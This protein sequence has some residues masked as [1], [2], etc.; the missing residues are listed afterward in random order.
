MAE[1]RDCIPCNLDQKACRRHC[2]FF[3]TGMASTQD[4]MIT[5]SQKDTRLSATASH[6]PSDFRH[7]YYDHSDEYQMPYYKRRRPLCSQT[8]LAHPAVFERL[9]KAGIAVHSYDCHGHGRSEP[10]EERSRALIWRFHHVVRLQLHFIAH[11]PRLVN[12]ML[13][14]PGI[15]VLQPVC[16]WG[17][18]KVPS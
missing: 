3:I 5:V 6:I 13:C 2:L 16:T 4:A 8:L 10:Q 11:M 15:Y 9:A 1:D 12:A 18:L 17:H 14:C 7:A